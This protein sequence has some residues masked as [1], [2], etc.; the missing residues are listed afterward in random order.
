MRLNVSSP[1]KLHSHPD[2]LP[3]DSAPVNMHEVGDRSYFQALVLHDPLT[4]SPMTLRTDFVPVEM[5]ELES[6]D[7]F[8]Q[9]SYL[10]LSQFNDLGDR[11]SPRENAR[12]EILP[13]SIA[14]HTAPLYSKPSTIDTWSIGEILLLST[15]SLFIHHVCVLQSTSIIFIWDTVREWIEFLLPHGEWNVCYVK[16]GFHFWSMARISPPILSGA[17]AGWPR[18]L[19][20]MTLVPRHMGL[21]YINL[22]RCSNGFHFFLSFQVDFQLEFDTMF[23]TMCLSDSNLIFCFSLERAFFLIVYVY[24]IMTEKPCIKLQTRSFPYAIDSHLS[25]QHH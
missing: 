8:R 20:A 18:L 16:Y 23:D 11:Q 15:N 24:F 22:T 2:Q 3:T 4:S 10:L 9:W 12:N 5:C 19:H 14:L 6:F 21:S 17:L 13:W 7:S 25:A 1:D